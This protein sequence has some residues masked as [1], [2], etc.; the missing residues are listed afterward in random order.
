MPANISQFINSFT[1]DVA[2][3]NRFDVLI[4]VPLPLLQFLGTTRQLN[5]RCESTNLPGRTMATA[6]QKFGTNPTEKHAYQS[7]YNDLDMTFIVGNDMQEKIFFDSWMEYVNPT[8]SFDFNYKNDYIATLTINQYDQ[9]NKLTYSVN[10][11]D[12]FPIIVNQMDL[13][14]SADG[15]H[16]LTVVF[17]YRYWQNNSIQQLG[18]NLL[19]QGISK[20]LGGIGGTA[21]IPD[22]NLSSVVPQTTQLEDNTVYDYVSPN[23]PD[24]ESA[25]TG[26]VTEPFDTGSGGNTW[27]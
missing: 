22:S 4:P 1:K 27:E 8:L 23:V 11:I 12:A 24:T 17:A 6:E 21:T 26:G 2:R 13:D 10:I 25:P 3:Q 20:V 14:W 5:L 15:V 16:K 18:T 19:Q 9:Y 7:N